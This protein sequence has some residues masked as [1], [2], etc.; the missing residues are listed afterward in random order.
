[1]FVA[2]SRKYLTKIKGIKKRLSTLTA[3]IEKVQCFFHFLKNC[4]LIMQGFRRRATIYRS[5][6]ISQTDTNQLHRKIVHIDNSHE[7]VLCCDVVNK[8]VDT[9]D[10][11]KVSSKLFSTQMARGSF[12]I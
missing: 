9:L 2:R 6:E 12:R 11:Q 7:I 8:V 10:K 1:M 4:I 5:N 3:I